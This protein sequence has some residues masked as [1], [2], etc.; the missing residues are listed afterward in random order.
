LVCQWDILKLTL[1]NFEYS[2][3][4]NLNVSH[5]YIKWFS[6]NVI[7]YICDLCYSIF[8]PTVDFVIGLSSEELSKVL[9]KK[10]DILVSFDLDLFDPD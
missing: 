4:V 3:D 6:I 5:W 2:W 1:F 10:L 7:F 9:Y 8:K